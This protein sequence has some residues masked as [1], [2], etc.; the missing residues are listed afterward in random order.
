[1]DLARNGGRT[2]RRSSAQ[3][4]RREELSG[5]S[6]SHL[7]QRLLDPGR[8]LASFWDSNSRPGRNGFAAPGVR[9]DP[10]ETP[11]GTARRRLSQRTQLDQTQKEQASLLFLPRYRCRVIFLRRL[12][13]C[14]ASKLLP[15]QLGAAALLTRLFI[16]LS[17]T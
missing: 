16:M 6:L 17:S 3:T 9:R 4:R 1:F 7:R 8:R 11:R 12:F 10:I 14:S 15:S 13:L 5:R 2:G